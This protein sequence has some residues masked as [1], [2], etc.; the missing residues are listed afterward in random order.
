VGGEATF[1]VFR[2]VVV[3]GRGRGRGRSLSFCDSEA[4]CA[5]SL[6]AVFRFV[7]VVG[8]HCEGC[9]PAGQSP[10]GNPGAEIVFVVTLY[11]ERTTTN[12]KT[13][14]LRN[15]DPSPCLPSVRETILSRKGRGNNDNNKV[16]KDILNAPPFGHP[17]GLRPIP[18]EKLRPRQTTKR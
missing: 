12:R 2:F 11:K 6:S 14:L 18:K 3:V 1:V 10:R 16:E 5:E 9:S 13:T 8:R 4:A 15:G 17:V 7:V